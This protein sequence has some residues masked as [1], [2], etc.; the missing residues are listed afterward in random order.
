MKIRSVWIKVCFV[1]IPRLFLVRLFRK[2]IL[3]LATSVLPTNTKLF[4]LFPHFQRFSSLSDPRKIA[5]EFHGLPGVLHGKTEVLR[6]G[7]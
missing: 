7:R 2:A 6:H 5:P 3:P 1:L 4:F